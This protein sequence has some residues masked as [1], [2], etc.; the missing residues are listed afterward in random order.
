M[1]DGFAKLMCMRDEV[2]HVDDPQAPKLEGVRTLKDKEKKKYKIQEMKYNKFQMCECGINNKHSNA[3]NHVD[4]T[5][6]DKS[7][8]NIP[9]AN[10]ETDIKD[11]RKCVRQYM[12]RITDKDTKNRKAE[13]WRVIALVLDRLFFFL[14]LIAIIISICTIFP[15]ST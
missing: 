7:P 4:L 1:L 14:Y 6:P 13:E 12:S 10:M 9:A 3:N 15:R 8:L 5:S 2:S 11:I